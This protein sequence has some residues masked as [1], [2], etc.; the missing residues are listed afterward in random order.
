MTN[1]NGEVTAADLVAETLEIFDGDGELWGDMPGG[2][3][4]GSPFGRPRRHVDRGP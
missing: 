4:V 1:F 2:S 3:F